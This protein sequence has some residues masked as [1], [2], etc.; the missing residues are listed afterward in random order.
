MRLFLLLHQPPG[1]EDARKVGE[2]SNL[3]ACGLGGLRQEEVQLV[4]L[5]P[6][7]PPLVDRAFLDLFGSDQEILRERVEFVLL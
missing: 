4:R 2:L 1:G 7:G 5:F 6:R 3:L